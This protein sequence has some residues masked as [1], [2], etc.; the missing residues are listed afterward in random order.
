MDGLWNT[1]T[2][3][4]TILAII[5]LVEMETL[6]RSCNRLVRAF[7]SCSEINQAAQKHFFCVCVF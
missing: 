2:E 6:K 5:K 1:M 3:L 7:S 4:F